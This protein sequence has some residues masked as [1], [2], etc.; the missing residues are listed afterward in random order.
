MVRD[1]NR[2]SDATRLAQMKPPPFEYLCPASVEEALAQL[3]SYDGDA[4]I[5]AGGQSLVPMLNFRLLSP[6]ALVDINRIEGLDFIEASD[7][8]VRIGALVRHSAIER[9]PLVREKLPILAVAAREIG[10]LAIRNRGTFAG[11]VAHNDPAAEWPLLCT[12]LDARI[13][14]RGASGERTLAVADFFL[15]Y[16]GTALDGAELV[17]EVEIPGLAPNSG[18]AFEEFSRRRG[19]PAI[20]SVAATLSVDGGAVKRARVALGGVGLCALRA[21]QA[22]ALLA[23]QRVDEALLAPV[24][25]AVR[26]ASDPSGDVHAS[27]DFRRHLVGVLTRR[28]V[29]LAWER[30]QRG[31]LR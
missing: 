25:E 21:A 5:L 13:H 10:H 1:R 20:V 30:A 24:C 16:M 28:V 12:L 15:S 14:T 3:S 23:G 17:T 4:K 22:E 31:D 7:G 8:G 19:D 29:R 11:S 6:R 18:W 27:A 9:S 2:N 26:D